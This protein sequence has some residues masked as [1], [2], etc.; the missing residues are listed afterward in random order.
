MEAVTL[1]PDLAL[2]IAESAREA[3]ATLVPEMTVDIMV[4]SRDGRILEQSA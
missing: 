4:I 2:P 1:V 3:A